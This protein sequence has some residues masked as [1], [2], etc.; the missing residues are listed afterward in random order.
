MKKISI[1][2]AILTVAWIMLPCAGHAQT[3]PE[4][5]GYV[6]DTSGT[7]DAASEQYLETMLK[8]LEDKTTAEIAVAVV[9]TLGGVSV[10]E[11]AVELF[12]KW[13]P[14]NAEKDNGVLFV[15]AVK[16]RE[17]RFEI[18]YGLEGAIP[19][20]RAGRIRDENV[21]PAFKRGDMSA[22]IVAGTEAM[23]GDI[24][25]EYGI[26]LQSLGVN[27][28]AGAAPPPRRASGTSSTDGMAVF[29]FCIVFFIIILI[30]VIVIK[31]S[32]RKGW[33]GTDSSTSYFSDSGSSGGDSGG[34]SF[35]GGDSGG[36]GAS[37]DW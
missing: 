36:G 7:L 12:E 3:Y 10:E 1:L 34:D 21:I 29:F 23:A 26:T 8:A 32:K 35:G 17:M 20:A 37:G 25:R 27:S 24:C 19:D 14:G 9:D 28:P 31:V 15:V 5:Q 6:T 2:L 16:D 18:G 22:G 11:Y 13:K 4:H 30:C 33:G